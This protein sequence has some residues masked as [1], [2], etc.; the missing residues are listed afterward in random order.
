MLVINFHQKP[1]LMK[2][3]KVFKFIVAISA[4]LI[5]SCAK[6]T[7]LTFPVL[8]TTAISSITGT[9]A[10]SGGNISSDGGAA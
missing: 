5:I 10:S 9:T 4:L 3:Q 6:T 1:N 2:N 8:T 7:S